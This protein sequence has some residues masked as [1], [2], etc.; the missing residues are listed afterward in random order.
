MGGVEQ[1]TEGVEEG[2]EEME[3]AESGRGMLFTMFTVHIKA[4]RGLR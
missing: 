3:D 1:G 2:T 4:T